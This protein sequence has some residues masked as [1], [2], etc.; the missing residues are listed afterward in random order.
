M[1]KVLSN[2]NIVGQSTSLVFKTFKGDIIGHYTIKDDSIE[3]L[4]D[5]MTLRVMLTKQLDDTNNYLS[6]IGANGIKI[7]NET[8]IYKSE[9]EKLTSKHLKKNSV[10][11][12]TYLVIDGRTGW[13]MD[14]NILTTPEIS[15]EPASITI[16]SRVT[17]QGT[18]RA[19]TNTTE[20]N[21]TPTGTVTIQLSAPVSGE[22]GDVV[23]EASAVPFVDNNASPEN[24]IFKKAEKKR[25]AAIFKGKGVK[26]VHE[27]TAVTT[28]A[29]PHTHRVNMIIDNN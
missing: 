11:D 16:N 26:F 22:Q 23:T 1:V 4:Y 27:G 15:I 19:I 5:G 12:L 14:A 3:T 20:P 10:I 8:L 28:T 29:E 25:I 13:F 24:L 18:I 17:N 2:T 9:N 7:G 6:V 21:Y